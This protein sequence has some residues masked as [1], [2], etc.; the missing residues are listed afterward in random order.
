MENDKQ[1]TITV[2]VSSLRAGIYLL[3]LKTENG[4]VMRKVVIE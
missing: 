3:K 4:V 1:Q 2:D